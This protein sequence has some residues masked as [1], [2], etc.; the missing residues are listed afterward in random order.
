MRSFNSYQFLA[1][2]FLNFRNIQQINQYFNFE[3][4]S[5][6]THKI[7]NFQFE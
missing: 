6:C 1:K 3:S 5:H 7:V 4:E 2:T